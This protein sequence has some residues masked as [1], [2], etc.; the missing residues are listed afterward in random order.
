MWHLLSLSL[1]P[2]PLQEPKKK[3]QISLA[4]FFTILDEEF[5]VYQKPK[6]GVYVALWLTHAVNGPGSSYFS[7]NQS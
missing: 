6:G 4:L 2:F 1:F 7:G 5:P 3:V